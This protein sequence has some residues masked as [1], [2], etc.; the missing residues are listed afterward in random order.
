[1]S[2]IRYG[3]GK[4]GKT[5]NLKRPSILMDASESATSRARERETPT[6]VNSSMLLSDSCSWAE[7]SDSDKECWERGWSMTFWPFVPEDGSETPWEVT[8]SPERRLRR[9]RGK[10]FSRARS[11][12]SVKSTETPWSRTILAFSMKPEES[13]T[14]PWWEG[15]ARAFEPPVSRLAARRLF[16]ATMALTC[17]SSELSPRHFSTS[18]WALDLFLV[19]GMM[20]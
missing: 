12:S 8:G 18:C 3:G 5:G 6:P 20:A 9:E 7:S 19:L 13:D 2:N 10:R 1:M 11:S 4:I 17:S 14:L 16:S 15:P